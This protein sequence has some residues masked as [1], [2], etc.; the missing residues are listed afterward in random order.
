MKLLCWLLLVAPRGG[1]KAPTAAQ[2]PVHV[3]CDD[4]VVQNK[5]QTARCEGHVR[6]TRLALTLTCDR[7]LAHYDAD[8]RI[9]DLTCLGNVKVVEV[10]RV[11]TGDKG[12]YV[13]ADRVIT[14][15][16]HAVVRQRDD[17]LTG[18]PIL[19]YVDDDRV[20]AKGANLRG[21]TGDLP[22][23]EGSAPARAVDAG[24]HG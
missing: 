5:Q 9:V 15:T 24:P 6:A 16:G 12:V 22:S 13:E 18:E 4:M 1:A 11:A 23:P 19:F 3:T 7:S 2:A 17:V 20:V 10:D 21:K 14:L 8:G